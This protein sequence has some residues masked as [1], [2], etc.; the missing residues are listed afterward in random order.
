MEQHFKSAGQVCNLSKKTAAM[1]FIV[2]AMCKFCFTCLTKMWYSVDGVVSNRIPCN[3]CKHIRMFITTFLLHDTI[4]KHGLC[5]EE[6]YKVDCSWIIHINN[7]KGT[8]SES[9]S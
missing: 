2:T 8:Q 3:F 5:C 1:G 4:D 6:K 7:V 9:P